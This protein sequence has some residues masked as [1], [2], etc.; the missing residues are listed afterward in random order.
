VTEKL[1]IQTAQFIDG[2]R[3]WHRHM[4]MAQHGAT[5]AGGVN[6]Q[7]LS[8]EDIAAQKMLIEWGQQVTCFYDSPEATR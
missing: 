2:E 4:Q 8:P 7:A 1:T 5:A 3:L 6:R